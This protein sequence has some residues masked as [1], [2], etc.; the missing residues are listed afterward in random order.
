M[1][2][3]IRLDSAK[4][5]KRICVLK[6]KY[7]LLLGEG[8]AHPKVDAAVV[9]A[10]VVAISR[11]AAPSVVAPAATANHAAR[12]TIRACRVRLGTAV[13]RAVPILTPLVYVTAHII[14]AEFVGLL[15]FDGMRSTVAVIPVPSHIIKI[16]TTTI[17]VTFALLSATSSILPF[18]F[19]RETELLACKLVEYSDEGLAVVPR[20]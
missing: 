20:N 19:G 9:G 6:D 5:S 14:D 15:G 1:H 10:E 18:C 7:V 8:Q 11:A 16:V 3:K 12:P 13:V 17:L 2:K 4:V